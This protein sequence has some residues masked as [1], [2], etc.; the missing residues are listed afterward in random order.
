MV[1]NVVGAELI[2]SNTAYGAA[3]TTLLTMFDSRQRV[4]SYYL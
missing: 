3:H 4:L 2:A 1:D